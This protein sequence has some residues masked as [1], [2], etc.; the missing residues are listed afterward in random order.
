MHVH[1]ESM[2][3]LLA[4][5]AGITTV[6]DCG[7]S[8]GESIGRRAL[9][10]KG[11]VLGPRLLLDG[12]IDGVSGDV[13]PTE[14]LVDTPA[15]A[16]AA[17]DRYAS[18]GY[19]QVKIYNSV[20]PE[21]LPIIAARAHEHGLRLS[22]HIPRGMTA[23]Q[24]VRDG[25]DEIHHAYFLFPSLL[26]D[27]LV[28]SSEPMQILARK[29]PSMDLRGARV[30]AMISLFR[31]RQ[32]VVDPTLALCETLYTARPRRPAPALGL[33]LDRLPPHVQRK[34]ALGGARVDKDMDRKLRDYSDAVVRLTGAL[35]RGGVRLVAGSDG[36]GGFT[37]ERELELLVQAGVRPAEVLR[38]A[39]LGAAEI[40]KRDREVGAVEVGKRADLLLVD[41]DPLRDI[42]AVR[43]VSL[44]MKDGILMDSERLYA[45]IGVA[46]RSR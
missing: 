23:E 18:L 22:G 9:V 7:S 38:L 32:V 15:E 19:D 21:L 42:S 1:P 27:D 14:I 29:A 33:V 39:T 41:G 17:V 2:G 45:A 13:A 3:G 26:A 12:L 36:V 46:K 25:L 34:L 6:R 4:L 8:I 35:H 43:S 37:L 11:E 16:R 10:A 44:V 30:Q 28:G 20:A 31:S 40:M 24:A 5:A